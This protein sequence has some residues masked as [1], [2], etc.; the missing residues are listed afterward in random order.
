[1]AADDDEGQR[2]RL[3]LCWRCNFTATKLVS[4]AVEDIR[5][6]TLL[7]AGVNWQMLTAIDA[8]DG[9]IG[10]DLFSTTPLRTTAGGSL[11]TIVIDDWRDGRLKG[12]G[13]ATCV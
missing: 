11:V 6:G 7:A 3:T 12:Q 8:A 9:Q 10:I 1:M 5:L 2:L 13:N 4:V